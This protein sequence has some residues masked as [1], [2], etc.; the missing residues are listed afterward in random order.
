MSI[1]IV[2]PDVTSH[3]LVYSLRLPLLL[4]DLLTSKQQNHLLII[5]PVHSVLTPLS[6]C[7]SRLLV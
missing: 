2:M 6:V 7:S 1:E 4:F 3:S 5:R